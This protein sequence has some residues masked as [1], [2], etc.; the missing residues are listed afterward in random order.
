MFSV[1]YNRTNLIHFM[2]VFPN[3]IIR[4]QTLSYG[5]LMSSLCI[6]CNFHS[7]RSGSINTLTHTHTHHYTDLQIL[8]FILMF[9]LDKCS[10]TMPCFPCY[11]RTCQ[12]NLL[13]INC[14]SVNISSHCSDCISNTSSITEFCFSS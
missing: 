7:Y 9:W 4:R 13:V 11:V 12:F 3:H 10:F 6:D 2:S 1:T 8:H 14:I 5:F